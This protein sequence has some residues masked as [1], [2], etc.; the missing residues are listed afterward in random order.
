MAAPRRGVTSLPIPARAIRSC[1]A[2]QVAAALR[3]RVR[4]VRRRTPQTSF[5]LPARPS[6]RLPSA[7]I[8]LPSGSQAGQ[9]KIESEPAL[10]R[11]TARLRTSTTQMSEP[12][13]EVRVA[14][15]VRGERDPPC[16]RATTRATRRSTGPS[17]RREA[18]PRRHVD[19]P[20]MV[21]AVVGEPGPV[22]HV[23]EPVDEPVVRR[24]RRPRLVR[25]VRPRRCRSASRVASCEVEVT[26]SRV[27]SGDHSNPLDAARQVGQAPRLAAV[28]RQQVDLADVLA[29]LGLARA[30]RLL[31]DERPSIREERERPAVGRE[32]GVV[33][34]TA[35][36]ASA[37]AA[38]PPSG[39]VGTSHRARP[40]A[41]VGRG[42]GLER[43]DDGAAIRGRAAGRSR[44]A[45]GRGRRGEGD[46][47]RYLRDALAWRGEPSESSGPIRMSAVYHR[48][49]MSDQLSLRLETDALPDL[50]DFRPMQPRSL[51]G[52]VRFR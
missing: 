47:A 11:V 32:A 21:D 10:I 52:A 33:V 23:V 51:P 20:E 1:R 45:A 30:G 43:D 48:G 6:S 46:G 34:V 35:R 7:T 36:R 42:D 5:R 24:R 40:V 16:R 8:D 39:A 15:P 18:S 13:G 22:E 44:C 26:T 31:L 41:V 12:E 17:V 49:T 25:P 3:R 2:G 9:P 29:I 27:P 4:A 37:G 19:E 38:R 50:P 28:E 14:T